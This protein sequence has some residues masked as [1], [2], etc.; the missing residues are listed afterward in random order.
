MYKRILTPPGRSFFL[1]GLRGV[2][3]STW[4]RTA[5]PEAT[6]FDLLDLSLFHELLA[7]PGLFA[8][9][10]R[11]IPD[12]EWIVVDEIQRI[13]ALLNE[14]HRL[15]EE[16]GRRFALL[17]SSARKLRAA[18]TNLLAGRATRKEM[19]PL[20]PEE[21]GA[22]FD[23]E[24][25]L[26]LGTLP[27]VLASEEPERTL[28]DYAAF[29]L[30][31]EIRAEAAV[32]NVGGFVRFLPIAAL[33]HGQTLSVSGIARDAG[34]A[35]TTVAGYLEILEDTLLA[36]RLPAFESKLRVRER[37]R[38]KLYWTDPGLARARRRLETPALPGRS[39]PRSGARCSKAG[40]SACFGHMPRSSR[41]SSGS[42]TGRLPNPTPKW[43][44]SS[45]AAASFSPWKRNPEAGCIRPCFAD[46]AR[47]RSSRDS[48]AGFSPMAASGRSLPRMASSS[49]RRFVSPRSS[50][51]AGSGPERSRMDLSAV[52]A[53]ESRPPSWTP[54]R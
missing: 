15:I 45:S 16:G 43:T 49:G 12:R 37:R 40:F 34:V 44:S 32:R 22:H 39:R 8:G 21:M 33:L 36:W 28:R 38:P 52:H 30:R 46:S 11:G 18:G 47:S 7:E 31:E 50:R 3:K 48:P 1:F 14:V 23:L 25:A 6:R 41:S 19:F 5:L 27:L 26:R 35:R 9:M 24:Q 29:Y 42:T 20:T 4:A 51:L 10:L 54:R 53:S 17:G 2:G 13:P